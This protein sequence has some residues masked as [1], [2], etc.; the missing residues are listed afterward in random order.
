MIVA[1]SAANAVPGPDST[2]IVANRNDAES[3]AL[4]EAY[5]SA[6]GIPRVQMC[7]LD[8]ST[9]IDLSL[10]QFRASLL[11]PLVACLGVHAA[12]IE[13]VVLM[14]GVPLRVAIPI[15]ATRSERVSLAAALAVGA[16]RPAMTFRCSDN[17]RATTR[18]AGTRR[19]MPRAGRAR[20]A[21]MRSSRDGKVIATGIIT[22]RCW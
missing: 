2:A 17:H 14:R 3:V 19:V 9:E 22:A 16:R 20:T 4:G 13:A 7:L 21:G 10:E 6:R 18:C 1:P 11:D 12:R 15:D 5:R 8:L